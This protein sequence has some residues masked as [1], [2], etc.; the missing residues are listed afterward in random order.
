MCSVTQ[1]ISVDVA[2]FGENYHKYTQYTFWRY[3]QMMLV[4]EQ[5]VVHS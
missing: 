1:V 3:L 5:S 4:T 2:K